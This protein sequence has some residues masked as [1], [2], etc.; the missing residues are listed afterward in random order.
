MTLN[1]PGPQQLRVFYTIDAE[2]LGPLT[3]VM[4][5]N[6]EADATPPPGTA[7]AD[8]DV[9]RRAAAVVD[10]STLTNAL[11]T[12]MKALLSVDDAVL[13][14][15]ECWNFDPGT[16]D[17]SY[18]SSH[19]LGLAGTAVVAATAA[20]QT[21]YSFRSLEGGAMRVVLMETSM[22]PGAS[23]GYTDM[24]AA[25]Q[26]WVDYFTDAVSATFLAR[27]TSYPSAFTR[28]HPGGNEAL[29]KKRYRQ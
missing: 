17:A 25:N 11:A 15:A 22:V 19:N 5:L 8:I 24:N 4:Q 14:Y 6:F 9:V 13:D 26:D 12:L 23:L 10:L 18:V 1:F 27:D 21:I 7:F 16:F 3:H 28:A 20:S 29:F 2:A